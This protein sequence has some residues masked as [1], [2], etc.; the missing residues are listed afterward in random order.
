[1]LLCV[2]KIIRFINFSQEIS[3][4]T[5]KLSQHGRLLKQICCAETEPEINALHIGGFYGKHMGH[6]FCM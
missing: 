3:K 1:M 4:K 2:N 6:R 5:I